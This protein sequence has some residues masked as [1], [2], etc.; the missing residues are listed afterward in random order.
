MLRGALI[1]LLTLLG[2]EVTCEPHGA[3]A[4][5]RLNHE[6]FDV[7]VTDH[8]MPV[9][10]GLGL[11]QNLRARGFPGRIYVIS[12]ALAAAQVEKYLRLKVD[13][14][15]A[16]PIALSQLRSLLAVAAVA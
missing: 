4:I 14:V 6:A 1:Q 11:V 5:D 7:V 13:G 2:W 12:G 3:A 15:V 10:D 8:H 9:T 16:K